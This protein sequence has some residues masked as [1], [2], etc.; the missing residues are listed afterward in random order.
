[1]IIVCISDT[2]LTEPE[3]PSGDLLIHCGDGLN[4]G[5]FLELIRLNQWLSREAKKFKHG[6]L[7]VPGNHDLAFER[8]YH[9][10]CQVLSA[11]TVL[12]DREVE[13]EEIRIYGSPWVPPI[14][15]RWAF[16]AEDGFREQKWKNIP[17]GIDILVTHTPPEN[18][19]SGPWGCGYLMDE[20]L[21]RVKPKYS[22]FGH[23]HSFGGMKRQ[24]LDTVFCNAAAVGEDYRLNPF[25]Q[26][27]IIYL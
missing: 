10:A 18:M 1:M 17:V 19:L 4:R 24:L 26:P 9:Q 6:I 14:N 22:L 3:L 20:I 15:G 27:H 12:I 5:D 16:E 2:H 13:I 21:K 11:A 7:Y 8:D 23:V 25:Q